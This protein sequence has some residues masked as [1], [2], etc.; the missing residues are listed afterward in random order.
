MYGSTRSKRRS[1]DRRVRVPV[2]PDMAFAEREA[3]RRGYG[4][5]RL[6][7]HVTMHENL[8]LYRRLGYEETGRGEQAGHDRVFMRKRVAERPANPKPRV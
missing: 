8:T 2:K 3:L 6:Y 7:T 5:V 1:S 4:E